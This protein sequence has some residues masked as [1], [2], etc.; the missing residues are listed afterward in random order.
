MNIVFFITLD[1]YCCLI[2]KKAFFWK[3]FLVHK[4]YLIFSRRLIQGDHSGGGK[5]WCLKKKNGIG[6]TKRKTRKTGKPTIGN[7]HSRNGNEMNLKAKRQ[8]TPRTFTRNIRKI[9]LFLF[10]LFFLTLKRGGIKKLR[11][12]PSYRLLYNPMISA[13]SIEC[14]L[15]FSKKSRLFKF[16]KFCVLRAYNVKRYLCVPEGGQGPP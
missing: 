11:R 3:I 16:S 7:S 2:S 6:K 4:S 15:T 10:F 8:Q 12:K 13:F 9:F 5:I 14:F 1:I